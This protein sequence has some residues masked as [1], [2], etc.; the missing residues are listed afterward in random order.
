MLL[1]KNDAAVEP[2]RRER[3]DDQRDQD[4]HQRG[5][6]QQREDEAD[7]LIALSPPKPSPRPPAGERD[8]PAPPAGG[9][10]DA[11]WPYGQ[12]PILEISASDLA[13][14]LAGSGWK[15]TGSR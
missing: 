12:L 6:R 11:A 1:V 4:E 14:T 7:P 8:V 3:L 15:S 10:A 13:T 9:S 2:D 5:G